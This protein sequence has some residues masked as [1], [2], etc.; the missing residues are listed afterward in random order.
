MNESSDIVPEGFDFDAA[1][2]A[3]SSTPTDQRKCC[4]ECGSIAVVRKTNAPAR[5]TNIEPWY[6]DHCD[7]HFAEPETHGESGAG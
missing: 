5:R 2:S 4:P 7:S 3:R 6:C 1:R